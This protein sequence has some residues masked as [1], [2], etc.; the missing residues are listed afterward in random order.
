MS[1]RIVRSRRDPSRFAFSVVGRNGSYEV[2]QH[3]MP[4]KGTFVIDSPLARTG[5]CGEAVFPQ[6]PSVAPRCVLNTSGSTVR[7]K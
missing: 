5:Q 6:G 4:L 1:V 7:C 2:A 3:D